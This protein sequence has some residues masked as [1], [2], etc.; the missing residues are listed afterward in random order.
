MPP[1]QY[2]W[3]DCSQGRDHNESKRAIRVQAMRS[4]ATSRKQTG[5][6]GK[7]NLGQYD[8]VQFTSPLDVEHQDARKNLARS[9]A[10]KQ[11]LSV[12]PA[13]TVAATS[14]RGGTSLSQHN[15]RSG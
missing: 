11:L 6:W 9:G 4:T 1:A 2:E 12:T 8:V 15:A 7:K 14:R 5:T 3:V 13:T 10:S